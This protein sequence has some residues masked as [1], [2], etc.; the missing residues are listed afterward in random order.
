[1]NINWTLT[2]HPDG[3]FRS[4][5]H[6][7]ALYARAGI[8]RDR[9]VVVYCQAGVR[10]AHS[11]FVLRYL[12]GHPRVRVYDGSWEEWGNRADLPVRR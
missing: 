4:A 6:L 5:E 8:S 10:A 11:W 7:R 1:V 2:V 3:T 9:E 12:L